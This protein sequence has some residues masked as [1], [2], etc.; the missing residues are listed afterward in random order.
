MS[1]TN[2]GD[3]ERCAGAK[4]SCEMPRYYFHLRDDAF[5]EDLEGAE[6]ADLEAARLYAIE[7]AREIVCADLKEGWL[8]LD[9]S[10][11]IADHDGNQVAI[12]TFRE[13]FEV[14]KGRK[15]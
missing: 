4:R 3:A 13:A 10:I 8:S 5:T 12:V 11:E 1:L 6:L 7:N 9:Q 14:R 15:P 2:E